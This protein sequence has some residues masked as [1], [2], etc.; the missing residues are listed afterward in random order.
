[1]NNQVIPGFYRTFPIVS[2]LRSQLNWTQYRMLIQIEGNS[3][4]EY[5]ELEAVKNGWTGRELDDKEG[6]PDE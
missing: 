1:M 4:R 6:G 2:A 3:K 5:Y